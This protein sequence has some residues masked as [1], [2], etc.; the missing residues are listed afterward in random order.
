MAE[1][2]VGSDLNAKQMKTHLGAVAKRARNTNTVHKTSI[3]KD[4]EEEEEP[5][6]KRK[7]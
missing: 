1:I 4:K 5:L 6:Q 2:A 3:D 7:K